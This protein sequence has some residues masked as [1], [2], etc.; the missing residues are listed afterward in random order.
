LV[1]YRTDVMSNL[2]KMSAAPASANRRAARAA[3]RHA[4]K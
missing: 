1:D 4:K 2:A 3:K